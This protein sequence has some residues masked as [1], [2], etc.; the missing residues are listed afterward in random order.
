MN[1]DKL[2]TLFM[3]KCWHERTDNTQRYRRPSPCVCG[4]EYTTLFNLKNH[5]RIANPDFSQPAQWHEFFVWLTKEREDMWEAFWWYCYHVEGCP[6]IDWDVARWL[7]SDLSRFTNLFADFLCLPSTIEQWGWE[8]K[9]WVNFDGHVSAGVK[10]PW[11][12]YAKEATDENNHS[13]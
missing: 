8:T 2:L 1:K 12:R 3:G 13:L 10:T 7:F 4:K 5:F 9:T 11:A 6:R